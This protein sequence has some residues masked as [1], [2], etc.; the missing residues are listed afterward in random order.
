MIKNFF[1]LSDANAKTMPKSKIDVIIIK[2]PY[3]RLSL[4]FW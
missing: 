3:N 1:T 2:M 4:Q